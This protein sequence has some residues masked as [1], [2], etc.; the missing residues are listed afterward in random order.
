ME[1]KTKF[2]LIECYTG[3][4]LESGTDFQKIVEIPKSVAK[5]DNYGLMRY[6]FESEEK[7]LY[8][9]AG[10]IVYY[11]IADTKEGTDSLLDLFFEGKK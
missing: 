2:Y 4:L 1:N 8:I 10:P 11:V 7:R 3:E 5:Q 9:D 6:W